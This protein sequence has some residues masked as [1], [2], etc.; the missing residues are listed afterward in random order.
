MNAHH[1]AA[2]FD[3]AYTA[4]VD[5]FARERLP[6][7]EQWPELRF[8]LP[9]LHY[10]PRLNCASSLLDDAIVEAHGA[11]VALYSQQ[12]NWTYVELLDRANRIANVL[13]HDLG[14]VP[15][16]RVL[17]RGAN[18]PMLAASWLAVMK[19]GAI[20]VTTMPMLRAKELGVM[21]ER[22]HI[23]HAICEA[24]LS[25]EL[26]EA[27]RATGRLSRVATYGD[28]ALERLM[29][30][31]T[32]EFRNVPTAADDVC[33]LAF[34]SGT[35]GN[36]KATMH[37]HRDVM[38]MR[39]VVGRHLLET[40]PDDI[41]TG[42]PPL[43]FTFGL[44]ALLVFPLGG[45]GAVALVEQPTPDNLLE[46]IAR[47]R[48]TALFTAPTAYRALLTQLAGRDLS[49]LRRC[50]SAGEA[51]PKATSDA[52]HAATGMRI[53]DGIGATEMIHIFIS[54]KGVLDDKGRPLSQ[55]NAG[56]LAVKGPSGCRYLD[57]PR[58]LE[59]VQDG[60]NI[61]GDR[62]YVDADGYFWFQARADDMIISGGYNIAGP[63]VEAALLQHPAVRECAVIGARDEQRGQI[64]KAYVV[65][66]PGHAP[67]AALA[68][69]LQEHVKRS[70]APYKY[71]R[72]VEFVPELPKTPTGKLQRYVLRQR[73]AGQA[74]A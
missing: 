41:Y 3:D 68:R 7:R 29:T 10:P 66:A 22:A 47:F 59:Y 37:F 73:D 43:G 70:I 40:A 62:Y 69:E 26:Q 23:D 46:T 51:L 67:D 6:P 1:S 52:W 20:A 5:T 39:D 15:G 33:L 64:V 31:R 34:T 56:R 18:S 57:D 25:A 71:P 61:T 49:S 16:N 12:G 17:L 55:P 42:S 32:D 4:H 8:D 36:P 72:A 13:V 28:G 53:I 27:A 65:A 58:Q 35:T 63:E 50:I 60:W 19:V 45:R 44:G 24:R 14:V 54:A 9:E 48:A 38:V 74:P 21:A 11:R 2:S 30:Q